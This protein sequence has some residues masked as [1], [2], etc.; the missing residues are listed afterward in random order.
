[1]Q[2]FQDVHEVDHDGHL[3]AAALRLGC[4]GLDLLVAAVCQGDPGPGTGGV[5]AGGLVEHRR[6]D[7][8]GVVCDDGGQPL[9]GCDRGPLACSVLAAREVP[10]GAGPFRAAPGPNHAGIFRCTWLSSDYSVDLA[11]GCCA[12]MARWQAVQTTRVF[13]RILAM[14]CAHAGCGRSGCVRS[15]S[16]QTWW[17][18][19]VVLRSHHSH[20]PAWSREISSLG[21]VTGAGRRSLR[22]AFCCLLRGMPPNVA[23]CGFLPGRSTLAS[24]HLRGPCGVRMVVLYLRAI[25]DTVE[26]CL[27]ASV[28]S[29]EVLAAHSSR[30]SL[31]TSPARR[32]RVACD[33]GQVAAR[34]ADFWRADFWRPL[35]EDQ[36]R[37]M[38]VEVIPGPVPV[39]TSEDDLA[40]CTDIL[41]ENV[42]AHTPEGLAFAVR[43][44]LR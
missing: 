5:A 11:V 34:R 35:A 7:G 44:S 37:R 29:I 42:F 26:S 18:S 3:D 16:F 38:T 25:F 8:R 14:S 20:R 32:C 1:P 23:T 19:T 43:V 31:Q 4:D 22:T 10:A 2:V 6:D 15:A 28:L 9:P 30:F 36:D 12:W 13:L 21:R 41:L 27:A 39:G 40:A 24:K 33:A 17:I